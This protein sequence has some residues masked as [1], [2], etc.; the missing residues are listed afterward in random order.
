MSDETTPRSYTDLS[1][2]SVLLIPCLPVTGGHHLVDCRVIFPDGEPYFVEPSSLVE[3]DRVYVAPAVAVGTRISDIPYFPE[4]WQASSRSD[5]N[6]RIDDVAREEPVRAFVPVLA[7]PT[8]VQLGEQRLPAFCDFILYQHP[9]NQTDPVRYYLYRRFQVNG[10]QR[11][12]AVPLDQVPEGGWVYVCTSYMGPDDKTVG[13]EGQWFLPVPW[14][15]Q[16]HHQVLNDVKHRTASTKVDD[17]RALA[18]RK[19]ARRKQTIAWAKW[20][21]TPRP[22]LSYSSEATLP[23]SYELRPRVGIDGSSWMNGNRPTYDLVPRSW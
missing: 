20:A 22:G 6:A 23:T 10:E 11:V 19:E 18:E 9:R 17:A 12:N 13:A 3:G 8:P 1:I 7:D 4:V 14:S 2:G 15:R 21:L 16:F 5:L